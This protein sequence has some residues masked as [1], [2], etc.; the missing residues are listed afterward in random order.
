MNFYKICF[1]AILSFSFLANPFFVESAY[2][3]KG[4]KKSR[5]MLLNLALRHSTRVGL[6]KSQISKLRSLRTNFRKSKIMNR[7][8][9]RIMKIDLSSLIRTEPMNMK[10]IQ[11]LV[12]R[13]TSQKEIM[14]ISLIKTIA[15]TK[16][17]LT[18]K[19]LEEIKKIRKRMR[20]RRT[21]SRKKR[22]R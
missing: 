12:Q 13:I 17:I 6:N 19:Q 22:T 20:K 5:K 8:R 10:E 14:W 9:I 18:S 2:A 7:A 15:K 21:R 11:K 1:L 16:N 4:K 3:H